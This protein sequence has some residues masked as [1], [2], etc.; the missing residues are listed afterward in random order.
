MT[1]EINIAG[2]R[3]GTWLPYSHSINFHKN[4]FWC[5][6][7]DIHS[8]IYHF[9]SDLF[10]VLIVLQCKHSPHPS[11]GIFAMKSLERGKK[12]LFCTLVTGDNLLPQESSRY[13]IKYY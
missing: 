3:I 1:V 5:Q 11:E 12:P 6:F 8:K 4:V 2:C 9:D 13:E 7:I 10:F